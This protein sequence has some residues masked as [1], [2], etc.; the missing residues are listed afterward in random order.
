[1]LTYFRNRLLLLALLSFSVSRSVQA[2]P[3]VINITPTPESTVVQLPFINVIFNGAVLGVNATDL[4]I[5]GGGSTR[6]TTNNPNDYTFY[7]PVPPTGTV[8]VAWSSGHGI[9]DTALVP[10]VGTNWT[11]TLDTNSLPP[12][13]VVISE[14]MADNG[15]GIQDENG[16]R[17]D[18]IELL[19]RG[20]FEANIG[21]W[22]ISD[23]RL[24][25]PKWKFP[26]GMPPIPVNGYLR[27]WASEKNRTN[28]LAPL[29]LNFKLSKDAGS[30]LAL[31]DTRTNI[32]S[33]F[34]PYPEQFE[35]ISYGRDRADPE[36]VGYFN[37]PTPGAPNTVGGSGFAADPVYSHETGIYTNASITLTISAPAGASIRYTRD[38][39]VPT[40]ASTLYTNPVIFTNNT[41]FKARVF[42]S[43]VFPSR[44]VARNFIFL[45]GSAADFNSNLPLLIISTEGRGMAENVPPGG[46]R[47]RGSFALIDTF[48][49]RSSIQ[50]APDVHG[51]LE[52]EVAGQTSASF[53]KKPYRFEIQNEL[54]QDED[55]SLLGMPA[56]SDWRLR[57]PWNDKTMLNDF[58]AYEL[59]EKMG[60]YS[61]RR[62]FVEV[63]VDTGGG[64]LTYPGDYVGV[65]V[66]CENIK[67][68]NDRVDVPEITPFATNEPAIT[69]GYIFKKDKDSV[70]DLNFST[71][72]NSASGFPGEA[73]KLHEPKPNLLRTAQGVTTSW[74]SAGYTA[75]GSN[76]LGYL[77]RYLNRMESALYTNNW[78][79]LTGTNHY[80]HYLDVDSFVDMHWIVEFNKQIDGYRLSSFFTKDRN[81]K[82]VSGPI[83][84]WNLAYGNANYL[85]GGQ[86][87][88][89][90]FAIQSQGMSANEHIWLRRLIN[91]NAA[92]GAN[93][94]LGPGGDPDF[95]QKIADRWSVLRTNICSLE[96]T[97]ARIDELSALLS[98]A[99]AR[100][101]WSKYRAALIGVYTWPNPDGTGNGRD[102]NFVTPTNYLGNDAT[103]IIWQMK[104]WMTGRFKWMDAQFTPIPTLSAIDGM[105]PSG[106][107]VTITGPAG[108]AIYYTV[109]GSDPR[110]FQGVTNGVRYT[111]PITVNA[112]SRIVAR[113]RGSSGF[114][115]TWS[116]P[117]AVTLYTGIPA[118]RITEIMYHP[119][120][121][122][123]G[124]TNTDED[125]EYIE[126]KNT[127]G[128]PLSVNKFSLGGGIQ[129]EF[130]NVV[131]Q[132]GDLAVVVKNI[133]AFQSRYGTGINVLGAF[134][135]NLDNAGENIV[136]LGGVREPI[137]DFSYDDDWYPVTDGLGFALTIV[138]ENAARDTWG[139]ASSWRAGSVVN[140][141]P[142]Q[143]DPA[144]PSRPPIVVSEALTHTDPPVVDIIE[145]HNPG[146]TPIDVGGW[147]LS[148]DFD[149][150]K[151]YVIP[152]ATT[153]PAGGY[154]VFNE[155]DHFGASFGLSSLG[156]DVWLFSGDG[157]NLTGYA[158]GFD[159][160]PAA[161]GVSFGRHVISTGADHFVAQ[162]ANTPGAANAGPLVGPIVV[163]EI[164]YTPWDVT[165]SGTGYNNTEDEF[166]EIYNSSSSPVPLYD[167]NY[168]TNTWHLR[169]AVDFTFATG[170]SIPGQSSILVVSF[171][172]NNAAALAAFRARNGVAASVPVYGPFS[173]RLDNEGDSVELVRPDVP[174]PPISENPGFVPYILVERIRYSNMAPW[175]STTNGFG[176]SLQRVNVLT[177]GNDPA[178]WALGG[179]SAGSQY[180][181][182]TAPAITSQPANTN[183]VAYY[184]QSTM[185]V[186]ASGTGPLRY[187]W[188]F[189]SLNINDATNATLLLSNVQPSDEGLYNVIVFNQA[190]YVTSS[191][192][193]LDVL[194]PAAIT[195]Q[196]TNPPVYVASTNIANYGQN[197][198]VV[199]NP[200]IS[201]ATFRI[202]AVSERA[203]NFQWYHDD[204]LIPGANGNVYVIDNVTLDHNGE[205]YCVVTDAVS[206]VPSQRARLN[207]AVV[208]FVSSPY[209]EFQTNRHPQPVTAL[210]GEDVT[211][212]VVHGG[213]PPFAYRWRL[214]SQPLTATNG[215]YTY[216]PFFTVNNVQ[217]SATVRTY[218]VVITNLGNQAPGL[219]SPPGGSAVPA[220]T[221][222]VLADTDGDGAPDTWE[223]QF[224]FNPADG[225]DGSQDSDGDGAGNAAEWRAGTDPTS[226]SSHLRVDSISVAGSTLLSFVALA[227]KSYQIEFRD[228]LNPGP[229]NL[230]NFVSAAS[231]NRTVT[232]M[233]TNAATLRYYRLGT[234][235][236][237]N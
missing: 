31:S 84:D 100:D 213:T 69:G 210:V 76:Q 228:S 177:Y 99:A 187:Q 186:T 3:E 70:G 146:G 221:L 234:P 34:N 179:S 36:L 9:T 28:P 64:R 89:W 140:G 10:F 214:N 23:D 198:R 176:F 95:N 231:T 17:A 62:K 225:S 14:F 56:D 168:P 81:G 128:S 159:F 49:G 11:Y 129:F 45:D 182:G 211:F 114:Y 61:V 22:F 92:M 180:S 230:L 206:Y 189:G 86:T 91:G 66:L 151:K 237:Q 152:V 134:T 47:T 126:V 174:Q 106:F 67:A 136:L 139:L 57:N 148:D 98:E 138:D 109:D 41:T 1:M 216:F 193:F 16:T 218:S 102:V 12:P 55:V 130:P 133:A 63:F 93:D 163:T 46:A 122:P 6:V 117:A 203:M 51:F 111:A 25:L 170:V 94:A 83:W 85:N 173:G 150:P 38:G 33:S 127:G 184:G 116:G 90:Y 185:Q 200:A 205:Y 112:N 143:N 35:D 30:F 42:Q 48:R 197:A 164:N 235:L 87:N 137:L 54:L 227:G 224:G 113:A 78:L 232:V 183:I 154:V 219:L 2:A 75:A 149:T 191:S 104:K 120:P 124:S 27:I 220:A 21:G 201:N 142:G 204:V 178:N 15:H 147:F 156:D 169:D 115:N 19:N 199:S 162:T 153:I 4:L 32:V 73:L 52:I 172:P 158:H 96:N 59:F 195:A 8:L 229:W 188:R 155:T 217:T 103:S 24:N 53:P 18:W 175:P 82:V 132:P 101:L 26:A 160:G 236:Q 233:D 65:E 39:T 222:T 97:L 135:G 194:I 110:G 71:Q 157:V 121:A 223:T 208:P 44:V 13:N 212:G 207:V 226:A 68:N 202:T 105:V 123:P 74:P 171:D 141:S 125:F 20:P 50:A 60:H 181:G 196:P 108:A 40:A 192:A 80:S 88:G 77:Q 107:T 144:V 215:G 167:V 72:G 58:L 43:G 119:P 166:V 37:T 131:L 161:N 190:G 165:V 209:A 29:H 145:L 7:F 118:L 79:S 5:N